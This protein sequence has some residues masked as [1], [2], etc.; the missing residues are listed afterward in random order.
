MGR[1][2]LITEGAEVVCSHSELVRSIAVLL[3]PDYLIYF[4][5]W[6]EK[7]L[8]NEYVSLGS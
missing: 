3:N 7:S 6:W 4:R 2:S 5:F 8:G 1:K